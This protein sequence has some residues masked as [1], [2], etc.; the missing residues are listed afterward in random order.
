MPPLVPPHLTNW[1]APAREALRTGSGKPCLMGLHGSTAG[2]GLA[3]LTQSASAQALADRSWLI[4][5]KTDDDAERLYRDTLF[6]RTLCGQSGDDLALFPKWETLPYESTVPHIDLVARR[7]QTL[8]R[9]CTTAR[10]VLFTSVPA[11]TQRVLPALVFTDAIL[12][13]QPNSDVE[14]EVL[15]SSLLRLGYRKGSERSS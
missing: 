13:F 4:V 2:F 3:L 10:T 11:L 12:Q 6:F 14:R 7:M 1:L 8:N 15:V 5:A 9:L